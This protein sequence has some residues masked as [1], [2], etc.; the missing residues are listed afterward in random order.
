MFIDYTNFQ[1]CV[2]KFDFLREIH[3]HIQMVGRK[4][5]RLPKELGV[6]DLN[7][8]LYRIYNG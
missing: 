4:C 7:N 8:A 3:L 6:N 5:D 2:R 1:H